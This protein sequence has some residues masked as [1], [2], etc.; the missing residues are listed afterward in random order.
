MNILYKKGENM[1]VEFDGK[2]NVKTRFKTMKNADIFFRH[3]GRPNQKE[4]IMHGNTDEE[5][6][7]YALV[8]QSDFDYDDQLKRDREQY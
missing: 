5:G 1:R 8:S 2:N 6:K 3:I 4:Y 7:K